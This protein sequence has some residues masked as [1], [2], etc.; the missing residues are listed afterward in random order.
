MCDSDVTFPFWKMGGKL[1]CVCGLHH[2]SALIIALCGS[3]VSGQSIVRTYRLSLSHG[4]RPLLPAGWE[5][6]A[7]FSGPNALVP[8]EQNKS[9]EG[10]D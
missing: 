4:A 1:V 3:F 8:A 2:G 6:E 5:A 10:I 7:P 9:P